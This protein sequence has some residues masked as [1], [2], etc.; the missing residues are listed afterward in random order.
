M[1]SFV[2]RQPI[3]DSDLNVYAYELLYRSSRVKNSFDFNT[4]LD[5]ASSKVIM[6]S[7]HD[8]GLE[9]IT[10]GKKAFV[11]FTSHLLE[12]NAATLFPNQTLI[13][14]VME[15]IAPTADVL[16]NLKKLRGMGYKIAL[17]RYEYFPDNC[18]LLDVADIIKIDFMSLD[19]DRIKNTIAHVDL[20]RTK[21]LAER[22][23]SQRDFEFAKSIGFTMFQGYFFETPSIISGKGI[24]PMKMNCIKLTQLV[25]Q[26]NGDLNYKKLADIIKQDLALSYKILRLVNTMHYEQRHEITD[27]KQ[28]LVILGEKDIRKWV[29]LIAMAG[30]VKGRPDELMRKS[31][32][33]ARF[34][35]LYAIKRGMPQNDSDMMFLTGMFSLLDVIL[36]RPMQ[37]LLFKLSI[38]EKV[39][40]ALTTEKGEAADLLN[41]LRV[42]GKGDWDAA[43]KIYAR[44]PQ[45]VPDLQKLHFEA[46]EWCNTVMNT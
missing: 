37:E 45:P 31:L 6:D 18:S 4:N 36:Q 28:A 20:R 33:R 46:I 9:K 12:I 1:D 25:W 40:S 7:F 23:E 42:S 3:F 32:V 16:E 38:P 13:I 24:D 44:F 11:N 41:Y 19:T 43:A 8:I 22:V 30:Y 27:I 17:D 35:E 2:A 15:N 5:L 21:L 29:S 10:G 34:M 26:K 39:E 14:E